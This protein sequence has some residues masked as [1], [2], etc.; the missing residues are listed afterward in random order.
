MTD[1]RALFKAV[2]SVRPLSLQTAGCGRQGG[3]C[4]KLCLCSN[5]ME[6]YLEVDDDLVVRTRGVRLLCV[7]AQ[8]HLRRGK[9][10][11]QKAS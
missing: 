6:P 1:A 10:G 4:K 8:V 7:K 2:R 11:F 9:W 3:H 5:P